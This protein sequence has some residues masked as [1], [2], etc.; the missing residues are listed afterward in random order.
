[1]AIKS[2]AKYKKS[3]KILRVMKDQCKK[4]Y[5]FTCY[6]KISRRLVFRLERQWKCSVERNIFIKVR[7][8]ENQNRNVQAIVLP[9][10][11]DSVFISTVNNLVSLECKNTQILILFWWRSRPSTEFSGCL[12]IKTHKY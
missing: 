7:K 2:L 8:L 3:A 10:I 9:N 4:S 1:M 12:P 5:W 6:Q 11:S